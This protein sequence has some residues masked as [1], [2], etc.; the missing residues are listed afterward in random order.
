MPSNYHVSVVG[1]NLDIEI[2]I[3]ISVSSMNQYTEFAPHSS[4]TL[5][6]S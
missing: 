5:N 1:G 6:N 4:R 2:L 3:E